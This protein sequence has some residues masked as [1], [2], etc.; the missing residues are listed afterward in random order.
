M[1]AVRRSFR[2]VLLK[3][4]IAGSR[5]VSFW[6]VIL[7]RVALIGLLVY[8][9]ANQDRPQFHGKAMTWRLILYPAVTLVVP[10]LWWFW[11]K[12]RQAGSYPYGLDFL[13]GL[14]A[15][16]DIGGN[17]LNLYDRLRWWDDLNHLVNP[18]FISVALGLLLL[19]G[20]LGR[21]TVIALLI[22]AGTVIGVVWEFAEYVTFVQ[23]SP[24]FNT[25][26]EDTMGDLMLDLAGSIAG[27]LIVGLVLWPRQHRNAGRLSAGG[28]PAAS[29]GGDC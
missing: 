8:A 5:P 1:A 9:A 20:P 27:A 22:G 19:R 25:A 7:L 18:V 17:T 13:V 14:P 23:R 12:R 28:R 24:E 29:P 11:F 21:L 2:R 16:I 3:G 6:V 4:W 10:A 15:L 26:Y